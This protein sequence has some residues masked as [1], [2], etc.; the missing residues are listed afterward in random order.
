[1]QKII[2]FWKL[3]KI[4]FKHNILVSS[5]AI[6]VFFSLHLAKKYNNRMFPEFVRSNLVSRN[7]E[8]TLGITFKQKKLFFNPEIG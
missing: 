6:P 8:I 5:Q 2:N 3:K 7:N 4:Q 1:M